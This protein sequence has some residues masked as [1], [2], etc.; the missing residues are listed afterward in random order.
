ML[1]LLP[2]PVMLFPDGRLPSGRWRWV[3]VVYG[4]ATVLWVSAIVAMTV[5]GLF[6]RRLAVDSDGSLRLVDHP[7]GVWKLGNALPTL[8][9]I[10][11]A[12]AAIVVQIRAFRRA[13]GERRQQI[14]WL[15]GG[16]AI[17]LLGLMLTLA[18]GNNPSG[19]FAYIG[20]LTLC[21]IAALPIA[22]GVGILKYRLFEIDRLISRTISYAIVTGLLAAVFLGLIAGDDP[23]AAVLVAGRRRRRDAGGGRPL[24][25]AAPP[26]PAGGRPP[27]QPRA[28]TTPRRSSRPSRHAS[29]T[30]STQR[31]CTPSS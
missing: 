10:A 30:R 24:Q 23:G 9:Y 18:Q 26:R 2:L 25:P 17:C 27:L 11:F 20:N 8:G 12:V 4:V 16:G 3:A 21:M 5:D 1:I 31:P 13:R 7:T 22:I 29:A 6:L 19:V 28:A 15:L 14:K